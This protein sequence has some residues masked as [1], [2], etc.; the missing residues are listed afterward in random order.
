MNDVIVAN[1]PQG[2]VD[3]IDKE[4]Q[5]K[6]GSQVGPWFYAPFLTALITPPLLSF[7]LGPSR[8]NRRI[9]GALGGIVV[10]KCK[11]LQESGCKGLCAHQ[12]KL[13]AQQFF[14]QTLGVP[15]SVSPNFET[16]ECQWSWGV[17]P[18]SIE[19]D[20]TFPRG[21]LVG[22]ESRSRMGAVKPQVNNAPSC[23]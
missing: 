7:L 6:P 23:Y 14:K 22:C 19:E 17:E 5:L 9:D 20:P 16:Q 11:F 12:C 21:C 10:E 18:L 1:L 15:V 4:G 13:P 8:V 3:V 2:W